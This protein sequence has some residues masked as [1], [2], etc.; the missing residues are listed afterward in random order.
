MANPVE[1]MDDNARSEIS[2][3]IKPVGSLCVTGEE[4]AAGGG[5]TVASG[6]RS[7]EKIYSTYCTIC[8]ATGLLN[9]PKKGDKQT[10]D[11]RL[12]ATGSFA[13][14]L[15]NALNGIRAMPP[16]GT[17]ADCSS[18]EISDSIEYMSGLSP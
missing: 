4:C 6:P 17:C 10:W 2:D 5:A 18:D 9:A 12:A 3:R 8:H 15:H 14:L 16:K 11:Q 7:G 1:D 13:A